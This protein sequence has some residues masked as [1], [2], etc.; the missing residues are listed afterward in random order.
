MTDTMVADELKRL[1][2]RIDS[3][4]K[5]IDLIYKDRDLLEDIQ[6]S[7]RAVEQALHLQRANATENVKT[8]KA[9]ISDVQEAVEAKID[10]VNVA[11]DEKTVIVKSAQENVIQKV[12]N[13]LK[14]VKK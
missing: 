9:D 5:T 1:S 11:T 4:E 8:I 6:V 10:Q 3:Q 7:I 12:V 2:R 14:G 13:K